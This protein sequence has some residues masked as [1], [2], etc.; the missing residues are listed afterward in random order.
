[1]AISTRPFIPP[2]GTIDYTIKA[3]GGGI[4]LVGSIVGKRLFGYEIYP[5]RWGVK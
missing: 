5:H 3:I 4:P 1:M 2:T